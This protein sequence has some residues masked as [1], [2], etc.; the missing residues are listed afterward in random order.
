M[1]AMATYDSL[2]QEIEMKTS[3]Y[4]LNNLNRQIEEFMTV[5]SNLGKQSTSNSNEDRSG[6]MMNIRAPEITN[7]TKSSTT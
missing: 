5:T 3:E 1:N 7:D 4:K 2:Y 6:D